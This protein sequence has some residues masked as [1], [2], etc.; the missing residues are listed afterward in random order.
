M[1]VLAEFV[2]RCEALLNE[3]DAADQIALAL[4]PLVA[5]P[6]ELAHSIEDARPELGGPAVI[7]RSEQLTVL[8]LEISAGF[9]SPPHNH[10]MWAVVGVYEGD[11]DNVFYRRTENGIEEVGRAVL[12]TGECLALPPDAVHGIANSGSVTLRALHVYGGDL[13]GTA[14]SQWDESTGEELPFGSVR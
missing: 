8:G 4:E 5:E 2:E 10:L 12:R 14:R 6:T 13:L 11:E 9:V 1:T 7:H 3:P